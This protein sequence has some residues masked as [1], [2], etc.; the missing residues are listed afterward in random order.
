MYYD[1]A[2]KSVTRAAYRTAQI[3]SEYSLPERRPHQRDAGRQVSELQ[4]LVW[5]V[6]TVLVSHEEHGAGNADIG[7]N[8]RV[9][10]CPARNLLVGQAQFA[11]RSLQPTDPAGIHHRR[12]R[13]QPTIELEVDTTLP[14]DQPAFGEEEDVEGLQRLT[15][16]AAH[17]EGEAHRARDARYGML[18]RVRAEDAGGRSEEHTSELKSLMR[19]SYA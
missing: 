15:T 19:I 6:R 18:L 13:P 11:R 1:A 12:L 10:P 9:V 5:V 4:R 3:P 8:R 2:S 14:A 7:E 17:L 16:L